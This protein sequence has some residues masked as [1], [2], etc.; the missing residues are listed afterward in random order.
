MMTKVHQVI[1]SCI[2]PNTLFCGGHFILDGSKPKVM[3]EGT[4]T[5]FE[6]AVKAYSSAK[7]AQLENVGLG[8]LLND[9]GQTCSADACSISSIKPLDRGAFEFPK[10]YLAILEK[11]DVPRNEVVIYW[12]KHM[13]NRGKKLFHKNKNKRDFFLKDG[14]YYIQDEDGIGEILVL[15]QMGA[16]KYGTC[17]CP[18]IMAAYAHQQENHGYKQSVNVYYIGN[19][20][21]ENIPNYTVIEKGKR[22]GEVLGSSLRVKN[23]YFSDSKVLKNF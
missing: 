11:Y 22:L 8:V 13:R 10:E 2:E 18:M 16:D 6:A 4:I 15:R 3:N 19:D 17:G 7:A 12:E 9:I 5:S 23:L 1:D 14:D 20:N 21:T